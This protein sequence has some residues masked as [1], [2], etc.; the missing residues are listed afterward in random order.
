M[1]KRKK[2]PWLDASVVRNARAR[3]GEKARERRERERAFREKCPERFVEEEKERESERERDARAR[4]GDF[5]ASTSG[6]GGRRNDREGADGR[7][8]GHRGDGSPDDSFST[9][10]RTFP[11]HATFQTREGLSNDAVE[12]RRSRVEAVTKDIA[13]CARHKQ[14]RRACR[15]FVQLIEDGM[16]PSPYTYA[17]LLNAYVNTG[18]MDGAEALM[19]RMS[20]VGCAPN[21]VA[22]TTMLKG[23]MLVADVDAA[24]RLLEGMKH[25]VAP[26]IRAVNTYIRVCVRCGSLT[27]ARRAF[28]R[29][30]DWDIV[31]DETTHRLMGRLLAQGLRCDEL[32]SL[33]KSVKKNEHL[34]W[35]VDPSFGHCQFW[36]AG[37]CE[38][39]ANCRFYHDPSI[40]QVDA[41][42]RETDVNDMLAHLYVNHAHATAMSGDV[43]QCFKSLAKAAESFAQD[44]DGNAAGLKDRDER[45][46]LFRQTSRDELKREMKRIKAFAERLKNGEQKAPNLDE[47]FARSLIFS[48][49]ILQPPERGSTSSEEES[50]I[51]EGRTRVES[52]SC[53]RNGDWAVAQAAT[54]DS[55][56]WISLELRHDRVYSIFSRAV[57]SG[58]SNF[59]AM[60]GD[61]ASFGYHAVSEKGGLVIFSDNHRYMQSLARM[62]AGMDLF[63]S[64]DA[65]NGRHVDRYF[66]SVGKVA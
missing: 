63:S 19:E 61:A 18:S 45:A 2:R 53:R 48:S 41:S 38:R 65:D 7:R 30:R 6:R 11:T 47:H 5:K 50:Q 17:S 12:W 44:D 49:Q 32:K 24:W 21:V 66:L 46:E 64:R 4:D 56:D 35:T 20:E 26:D 27:M 8:K 10:P 13:M 3:D 23:Y 25:P 15:A 39:G 28:E 60:G 1:A 55:S 9:D 52:R 37:K 29:V 54:D 42:A 59:A 16:V 58:A 36:C 40:E 57:F 31:P 62:L 33:I 51:E 14:L 22:Y 43:K 34:R